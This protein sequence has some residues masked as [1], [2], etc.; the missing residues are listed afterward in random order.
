MTPVEISFLYALLIQ[1]PRW[2][3]LI[4]AGRASVTLCPTQSSLILSLAT[5]T[6]FPLAARARAVISHKNYIRN[7]S[8]RGSQG[9]EKEYVR[10]MHATEY[11]IRLLNAPRICNSRCLI[12]SRCRARESTGCISARQQSCFLKRLQRRRLG[13][14]GNS[15]NVTG[16]GFI[17][18]AL[19]Y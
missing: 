10:Y 19:L 5:A 2:E 15:G 9:N 12:C 1:P 7:M 18:E 11:F 14:C 13:E 8:R 3:S 4:L 6:N 17:S 16:R